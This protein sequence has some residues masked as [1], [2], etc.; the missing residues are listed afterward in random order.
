MKK[1]LYLLSTILLSAA[2]LSLSSCLKDNRYV[3][4][5]KVGTVVDFPLGGLANFNSA[6]VTDAGDTIVKQFAVNV[7]S[8]N[9]PT[10]A[11]TLTLAVDNSVVASYPTTPVLYTAMP[12]D[13]YVFTANT[14]TV[15]AG[16]QYATISV[17]FYKGKLDPSKSYMLPIRITKTSAGTISG[18]YGIFYFHFIGNDFAGNYTWDFTRVPDGGTSFTGETATFNPVTPTQFEV[19]GGY[20]TGTIRYE[21]TF[22]KNGTGSSA[23]YSNFAISINKDDETNIIIGGAGTTI[24]QQ[25]LIVGYDPTHNYTFAEAINGLFKFNWKTAS[26][27]DCT[28]YYHRP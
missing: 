22:T 4:F 2:A 10:T 25:P 17:T 23:T 3:D 24:G 7:A 18:N 12:T 27:R 19:A 20:Y 11:T 5:S 9:V 14:V 6:A 13:A 26:G 28:D 21:V 16:K 15:P 8:P 1:K